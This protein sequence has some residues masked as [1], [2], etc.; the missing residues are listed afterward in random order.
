MNTPH[1]RDHY[2]ADLAAFAARVKVL[3]TIGRA[4]KR[5]EADAERIRD[6]IAIRD[7]AEKLLKK[8]GDRLA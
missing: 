2:G 5:P 7:K 8:W 1:N 4:D 6:L 3:E